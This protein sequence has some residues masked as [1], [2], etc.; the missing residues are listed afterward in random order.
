MKKQNKVEKYFISIIGYMVII[1]YNF[2]EFNLN[3]LGEKPI[4]IKE[5]FI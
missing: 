4:S 1:L 2:I 5:V 3:M